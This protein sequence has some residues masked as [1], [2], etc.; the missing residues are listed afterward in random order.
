MTDSPLPPH[1]DAVPLLESTVPSPR[2]LKQRQQIML[3]GV[4]I[5]LFVVVIG[6]MWLAAPPPA[7]TAKAEDKAATIKRLAV[8]GQDLNERE[9]WVAKGEARLKTQQDQI[10]ELL[11]WKQAKQEEEQKALEERYKSGGRPTTSSGSATATLVPPPLLPVA[12]ASVPLPPLPQASAAN[13]ATT[14]IPP[15]TAPRVTSGAPAARTAQSG[16]TSPLAAGG[17][18]RISF[19]NNGTAVASGTG[20]K[21]ASK[22]GGKG[23][24]ETRHVGRYIPAGTFTRGVLLGGLDA[25]AGGQAQSNPH[26]VLIKLQDN[27][28]LPNKFRTR[29][30]ECH[31]VG[32]GYGDISSERAYIRLETLSCV[33]KYGKII[34]VAMQGYVAGEDGKTGMRGRLVTKEGQ[35][36][37]RAFLAGLG[38]G[39]GSGLSQ[40][41]TTLS[42]SPLGATQSVDP[43]K[44]LEHGAYSGVGKAMDRLAQYYITLAEKTFPVV[45]IAAGRSVD[46]V[47]TKGIALE[48]DINLAWDDMADDDKEAIEP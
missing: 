41:V 47:L 21:V 1:D 12:S 44:V 4:G 32:A 19:S 15:P 46:V 16:S 31:V 25:P 10:E 33:L 11:R 2:K 24:G 35:L 5:V 7:K 17:I 23:E 27:S 29:T 6:G 38:S 39:I 37:G 34:E 13:G 36:L 26:P 42:T 14:P 3:I 22:E 40:S 48:E 8:P 30:R 20:A 45:E 28:I 18:Q 9:V 43:G